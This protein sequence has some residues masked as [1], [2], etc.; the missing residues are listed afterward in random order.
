MCTFRYH[1]GSRL[2][3]TSNTG[4]PKRLTRYVS[5]L[6]AHFDLHQRIITVLT[7][8]GGAAHGVFDLVW[9]A[10]LVIA[11]SDESSAVHSWLV[12]ITFSQLGPGNASNN[13]AKRKVGLRNNELLFAFVD[14]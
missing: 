6:G 11:N 14:I 7:R 4:I 13:R 8:R 12:L 1:F 3:A 5:K 10:P 2:S 9:I